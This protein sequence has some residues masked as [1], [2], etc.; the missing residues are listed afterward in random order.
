MK[1]LLLLMTLA[2]SALAG[3]PQQFVKGTNIISAGIGLG[4]SVL[5][6]SGAS[7]TPTLSLQYEGGVWDAV[8]GVISLGGYAGY[9]GY[10]YSANEGVYNFNESWHYT[11]IGVR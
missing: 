7:Q 8:P 4:S 6:F 11:I 1:K 3:H 5:S 10:S 2:I 9:K